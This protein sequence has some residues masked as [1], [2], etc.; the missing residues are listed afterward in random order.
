MPDWID[1]PHTSYVLAAY[2]VAAVMLLGLLLASLRDSH[3]CQAEWKKLR[4]QGP[5]S[6]HH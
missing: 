6:A 2:G 4:T 1:H 3:S 5:G